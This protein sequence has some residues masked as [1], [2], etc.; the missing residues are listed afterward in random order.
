MCDE[1]V[2]LT[3]LTAVA[4]ETALAR[5]LGLRRIPGGVPSYRG[6]IGALSVAFC[7]TGMRARRLREIEDSTLLRPR[8]G[9]VS[10]GLAGGLAPE[11]RGGCVIVPR[12]VAGD[13]P[14][15]ATDPGL[16]SAFA[17][18]GAAIVSLL[19]AFDCIVATV[20]K[21]RALHAATNAAAV[22]MESGVIG[23]WAHSHGVPFAVVR[24]ISDPADAELP[25]GIALGAS[26]DLLRFVPRLVV[27]AVRALSA[28]RALAR[29]VRA[30]CAALATLR[31]E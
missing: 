12:R 29:V 25:F 5:K 23:A 11:L 4:F 19:I 6:R 24:A 14:L 15:L 16:R 18:E 30:G 8:C 7:R 10:L 1:P 17:V 9:I 22:D 13:G 21:K 3:F 31:P 20:A 27:L 2:D 26:P 28:R